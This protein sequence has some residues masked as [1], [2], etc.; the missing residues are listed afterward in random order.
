MHHALILIWS[1]CKDKTS[2]SFCCLLTCYDTTVLYTIGN[3]VCCHTID[4]GWYGW[5]A[6]V[7]QEHQGPIILK[8][9]YT[10]GFDNMAD[11]KKLRER[12][13][14]DDNTQAYSC[15]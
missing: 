1:I 5:L 15:S 10:V 14:G 3:L 8:F 2:Q 6:N 7:G 4:L 13:R 9:M 11:E 12:E